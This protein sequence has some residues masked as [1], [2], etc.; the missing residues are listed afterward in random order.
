MQQSKSSMGGTSTNL[1]STKSGQLIYGKVKLKV[2]SE[3]SSPPAELGGLVNAGPN[4]FNQSQNFNSHAMNNARMATK[5][6]HT[7]VAGGSH[8]GSVGKGNQTNYTSIHTN[9]R[10]GK[11]MHKH[12]AQDSEAHSKMSAS[13]GTT[14]MGGVL[15][16]LNSP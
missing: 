11:K 13:G 2:V 1:A 16:L 10:H 14:L 3:N 7:S 12:S 15:G 4:S 6:K 8:S 9:I 5:T